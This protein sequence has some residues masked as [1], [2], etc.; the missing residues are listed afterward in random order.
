MAIAVVLFDVIDLLGV[1]V[2]KGFVFGFTA[3]ISL[4]EVEFDKFAGEVLDVLLLRHSSPQRRNPLIEAMG[5][6]IEIFRPIGS[7]EDKVN[8]ALG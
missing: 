3:F 5:P 8:A 7:V 6:R 2:P 4:L 1:G